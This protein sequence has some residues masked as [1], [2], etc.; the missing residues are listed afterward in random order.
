MNCFVLT[1]ISSIALSL[2]EL[3]VKKAGREFSSAYMS[4]ETLVLVI[5][6]QV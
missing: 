3:S 4:W 2:R 5:S 1:L 6:F